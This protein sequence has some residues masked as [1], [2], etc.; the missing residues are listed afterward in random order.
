[1]KQQD[2][3]KN[4]NI[5]YERLRACR[6]ERGLTQQALAAEMQTVGIHLTRQNISQIEC[7]KRHV[8]DFELQAFGRVLQTDLSKLLGL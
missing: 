4:E 2:Q 3:L 6:L 7:N 5:I 8:S 1:M